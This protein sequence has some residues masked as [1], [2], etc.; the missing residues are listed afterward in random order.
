MQ[1]MEWMPRWL[2]CVLDGERGGRG[3]GRAGGERVTM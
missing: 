3:M 2:C 1:R